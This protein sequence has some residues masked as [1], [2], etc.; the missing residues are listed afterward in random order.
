MMDEFDKSD[1]GLLSYYLGIEVEQGEK[2]I[3]VRQSAYACRIL[4]QFGMSECNATY[5]PMEHKLK[6]HKDREDEPVDPTEYRRVIGSLRY[7]LHTRPDLS[8]FVGMLSRYMERPTLIHLKDVKQILRYLKDT[9]HFG[10]TYTRGGNDVELGGYTDS[11]LASDPDDRR[12]TGG[13]VFYINNN[14][15]SWGLYKQR[16]VALSSYEAEYVAAAA[17]ACQAVWL[18]SVIKEITGNKL[19]LVTLF[20]DNR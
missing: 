16:T 2:Q 17:A 18:A 12:S 20:V 6:L 1:L 15:V 3:S 8:Y 13:I 19:K 14:L 7:L 9:I 4:K 11:D 5:V 10:L